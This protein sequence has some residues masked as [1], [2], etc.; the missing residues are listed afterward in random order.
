MNAATIQLTELA[1]LRGLDFL[2]IGMMGNP[3]LLRAVSL[4]GS[5]KESPYRRS[6]CHT[7]Y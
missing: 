3:G 7:G 1:I 5:S 6:P 2:T 4:H